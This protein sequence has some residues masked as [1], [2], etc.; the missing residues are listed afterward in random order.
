[1]RGV[2]LLG[3]LAAV[4]PIGCSNLVPLR[5]EQV[6]EFQN[7]LPKIQFY[8]SDEVVLSRVLQSEERKIS[9]EHQIRIERGKK[10]EEIHIPAY[11][12]G[13]LAP[14]GSRIPDVLLVYFEEP[15]PELPRALAFRHDPAQLTYRLDHNDWK[16]QYEGREFTVVTSGHLL[17]DVDQIVEVKRKQRVLPGVELKK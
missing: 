7:Q 2:V 9:R 8:I 14:T 17:V 4:A 10:I 6:V 15:S 12:P 13:V 5:R 16:V 3:L 11:T 1:M